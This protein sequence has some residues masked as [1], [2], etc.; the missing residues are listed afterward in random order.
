[1]A[2]LSKPA[3]KA[4]SRKQQKRQQ[5]KQSSAG[6]SEDSSAGNRAPAV[7]KP[8]SGTSSKGGSIKKTK[9]QLNISN[10]R[11]RMYASVQKRAARLRATSDII[12]FLHMP[13]NLNGKLRSVF[14][15]VTQEQAC[16]V[17]ESLTDRIDWEDKR[18][19]AKYDEC[20]AGTGLQ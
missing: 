9:K 15:G 7:C 18:L 13:L 14:Q 8:G 17:L 4:L 2:K 10:V 12:I 6:G 19:Q 5:Q 20:A 11:A 3:A 1:L 16:A